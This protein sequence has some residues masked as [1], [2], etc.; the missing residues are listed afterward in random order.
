MSKTPKISSLISLMK[1]TD[2]PNIFLNQQDFSAVLLEIAA[3]DTGVKNAF[4]SGLMTVKEFKFNGR[5]IH[6]D[7]S[8]PTLL[9]SD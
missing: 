7:D 5:E 2:M 1:N 9:V 4:K 8:M 3:Q 6:C